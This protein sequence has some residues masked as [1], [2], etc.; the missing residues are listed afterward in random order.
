MDRTPDILQIMCV[1]LLVLGI[2]LEKTI[3][4]DLIML[5]QFF[6]SL[7]FKDIAWELSIHLIYL[8][9]PS[10]YKSFEVG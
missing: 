3:Y 7:G 9:L 5:L 1:I 8:N 10:L 4:I 6:L 2:R